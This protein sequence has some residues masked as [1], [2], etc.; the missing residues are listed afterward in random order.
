MKA[1]GADLGKYLRKRETL[2]LKYEPW[3][4]GLV[5]PSS[6]LRTTQEIWC[7]YEAVRVKDPV[8]L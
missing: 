7:D 6:V 2:W 5:Q 4:E 3:M 8:K 1:N